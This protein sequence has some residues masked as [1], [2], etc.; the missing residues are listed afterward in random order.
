MKPDSSQLS[1]WRHDHVTQWVM[2]RLIEQF[3]PLKACELARSW[4][5]HNLRVGQQQV[6]DAIERLTNHGQ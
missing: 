4:D 1:H 5:D 6:L 2:Q 3:R